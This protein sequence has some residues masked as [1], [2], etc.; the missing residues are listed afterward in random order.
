M[1]LLSGTKILLLQIVAKRFQNY[2]E[3]SS[4][5]PHK[6]TFGIFKMLKMDILTILVLLSLTWAPMGV[7]ISKGYYSYKSLLFQNGLYRENA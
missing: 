6:T 4:E 2:P 5:R 1:W 7:K 3:F